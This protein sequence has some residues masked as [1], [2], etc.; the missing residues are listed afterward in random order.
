M[1]QVLPIRWCGTSTLSPLFSLSRGFVWSVTRTTCLNRNRQEKQNIEEAVLAWEGI[2][3]RV[4]SEGTLD[5]DDEKK[6]LSTCSWQ[7]FFLYYALFG[8]ETSLLQSKLFIRETW[9]LNRL[10]ITF[11]GG[12][13]RSGLWREASPSKSR[14]SPGFQ[15]VG[16]EPGSKE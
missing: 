1:Y 6:T 8:R 10:P 12:R 15:V 2:F 13:G 9:F 5:N 4:L 14:W 3:S 11:L 16:F 7:D